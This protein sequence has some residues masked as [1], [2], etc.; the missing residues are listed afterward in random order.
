[1]C[2]CV[3]PLPT[4]D[5]A[6]QLNDVALTGDQQA[7]SEVSHV[8]SIDTRRIAHRDTSSFG[9]NQINSVHPDACGDHR[10]QLREQ[11]EQRRLSLFTADT[12][13]GTDLGTRPGS[14]GRNILNL[15]QTCAR[16]DVF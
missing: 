5:E 12:G 16:G 8:V 11:G 2:Q 14:K 6:V 13:D 10:F 9:G 3:G 1:M 7:H 15:P 4:P